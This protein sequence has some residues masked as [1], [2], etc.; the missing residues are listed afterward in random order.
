APELM[1]A[2]REGALALDQL[3]AFCVSEDQ[4]RQRQVL[5]QIGP[6]TP[7]YAIRRAMTE[8]KVRVDDRRARFVGVEVYE[9]AGGA[10]LRD[11]EKACAKLRVRTRVE[12]V[13][14]AVREGLIDVE[15]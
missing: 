3:T 6:H 14:A 9:A 11:L 1:A 12:A 2:Y 5:D 13:A 7:A 15:E 10:V 8:A 4:E